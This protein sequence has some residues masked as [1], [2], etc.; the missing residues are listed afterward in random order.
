MDGGVGVRLR[1]VVRA[2]GD[3]GRRLPL[4]GES[5]GPQRAYILPRVCGFLRKNKKMIRGYA[6][7][8]IR[9]NQ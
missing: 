6:H 9:I 5:I 8:I 2:V 1:R 7:M 3:V 4:L